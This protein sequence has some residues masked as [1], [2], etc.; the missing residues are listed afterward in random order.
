MRILCLIG[1]SGDDPRAGEALE[2]AAVAAVFEHE[3][4]VCFL[5]GSYAPEAPW[6]HAV[7]PDD[8]RA[9]GAELVWEETS[10]ETSAGALSRA[11]L[12]R[13]LGEYDR[14]LSF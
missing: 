7:A 2:A 4:T 14:V 11:E 10:Q 5:A 1:V 12:L 9:Y 6:P 8:L 3:V 13:R